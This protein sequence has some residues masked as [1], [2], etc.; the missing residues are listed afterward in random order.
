MKRGQRGTYISVERST[1]R[2]VDEQAFRFR[3]LLD[4][5]G[6]KVPDAKRFSR[7]CSQIVGRR[8]TYKE[9]IGNEEQRHEQGGTEET[10]PF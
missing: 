10:P 8:L 4:E 7:L 3:N 5:D 6:E 9:L 2:Y 1:Y